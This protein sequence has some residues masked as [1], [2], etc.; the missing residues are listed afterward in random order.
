MWKRGRADIEAGNVDA[1][2][3]PTA[4]SLRWGVSIVAKVA[5][6]SAGTLQTLADRCRRLC[7]ENHTFY[8]RANIHVTV[9]SCDFHRFGVLRND[10]FIRAYQTALADVCRR[11][12]ALEIAYCGLNANRTGVIVQ[13]YPVTNTLQG[14]R[15]DLHNRLGELGVRRGPEENGVRR[16]AHTSVAVFGGA[17]A[18]PS[19]LHNWIK[20]NRET[21]FGTA[22]IT[23]L[24]LARYDRTAY[25]VNLVPFADFA[26]RDS[27]F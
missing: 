14:L 1:D 11:H 20:S 4:T 10:P 2:P 25:N 9:R 5:L 17:V 22:R 24:I 3:V 6:P 16:T 23:R 13:G 15:E 12:D 7:G 8:T 19:S 21:W 27:E 26:L 18:D